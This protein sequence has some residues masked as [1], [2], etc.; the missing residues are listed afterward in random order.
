ME[1]KNWL[2]YE[3][4]YIDGLIEILFEGPIPEP[5]E[6]SPPSSKETE[7][8]QWADANVTRWIKPEELETLK[9]LFDDFAIKSKKFANAQNAVQS[10]LRSSGRWPASWNDR[11]LKKNLS[12]TWDEQKAAG[13]DFYARA[14]PIINKLTKV[15]C[16]SPKTPTCIKRNLAQNIDDITQET[17][18]ELLGKIRNGNYNPNAYHPVQFRGWILQIIV[19]KLSKIAKKSK[20][21]PII[22]ID[23]NRTSS[24]TLGT[25]GTSHQPVLRIRS[26]DEDQNRYDKRKRQMGRIIREMQLSQ[27][28]MP[29]LFALILLTRLGHPGLTVNEVNKFVSQEMLSNPDEWP[30]YISGIE[31][32]GYRV[33]YIPAKLEGK[34]GKEWNQRAGWI[35]VKDATSPEDAVAKV[36]KAK[37]LSDEPFTGEKGQPPRGDGWKESYGRDIIDVQGGEEGKMFNPNNFGRLLKEAKKYLGRKMK[38]HGMDL[39]DDLAI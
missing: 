27:A 28:E 31:G 30:D 20:R 37:S 24:D 29:R 34:T 4:Y 6:P 15:T 13:A 33:R 14:M 7:I 21:N 10:S 2:T 25:R 38:E 8:V 1:F 11:G 19:S 16:R 39:P 12:S 35:G 3:E 36:K 32:S 22:D 23:P 17:G 26:D 9:N 18:R 5:T